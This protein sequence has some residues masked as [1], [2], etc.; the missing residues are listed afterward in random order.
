MHRIIPLLILIAVATGC[1][2]PGA[3]GVAEAAG[4]AADAYADGS[5]GLATGGYW[6][7]SGSEASDVYVSQNAA[8]AAVLVQFDAETTLAFVVVLA[9]LEHFTIPEVLEAHP[10]QSVLDVE[11]VAD[12]VGERR[13]AP[14]F[15]TP[16][17]GLDVTLDSY[18][19]DK[20]VFDP[21]CNTVLRS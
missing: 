15:D 8:C 17:G 19:E 18:R 3:E 13:W 20:A 9:S 7:E 12:L 6:P 11:Q 1:T 16:L 21:S 2:S 10:N 14:T 5:F 4:E